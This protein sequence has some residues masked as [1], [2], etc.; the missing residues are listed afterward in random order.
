MN[1]FDKRNKNRNP[2]K[3]QSKQKK[4]ELLK[5]IKSQSLN[6][7]KDKRSNADDSSKN[8]RS[9]TSNDKELAEM[10]RKIRKLERDLA[11]AKQAGLVERKAHS[12]TKELLKDKSKKLWDNQNE[13]INNKR[14][15]ESSHSEI[16]SKSNLIMTIQQKLSDK[17]EELKVTEIEYEKVT[18]KIKQYQ[19]KIKDLTEETRLRSYKNKIV[20]LESRL[21]E[22]EDEIAS[23][24]KSDSKLRES[25][26][27]LSNPTVVSML[28]RLQKEL[29]IKTVDQ[30]YPVYQLT[31]EVQKLTLYKRR[32]ARK[33]L[34][35]RKI[36]PEHVD[37][38]QENY[39]YITKR[40]EEWY[41]YSLLNVQYSLKDYD[42][43][44]ESDLPAKVKIADGDAYL[45]E[46]YSDDVI[47]RQKVSEKGVIA[48][49]SHI[50]TPNNEESYFPYFGNFN[51]LIIGSITQNDFLSRLTKHGLSVNFHNP[52]D[53]NTEL[54]SAKVNKADVIVVI[55]SK[56]NHLLWGHLNKSD[57]RIEE[58]ESFAVDR[59]V[60][61]I[62]YAGIRLGLIDLFTPKHKNR[63]LSENT[64]EGIE[65]QEN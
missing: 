36:S 45:L 43:T 35:I 7:N 65:L 28:L 42:E 2:D 20:S 47:L 30:Y 17:E 29:S 32:I 37:R 13:L 5:K 23:L 46:T 6:T 22:Y 40:N 60:A 62:R 41:F 16:T 11:A 63:G 18:K 31:E 55:T 24:K 51:V 57:E 64:K 21:E 1:P 56:I 53:E 52:F 58:I 4:A 38:S 10:K 8:N 54:I 3:D 49:K 14:M 25:I 48:R 15:L 27:R 61:R 26:N 44:S 34:A 33:P 12:V 9:D 39:G 19:K 59:V 50:N